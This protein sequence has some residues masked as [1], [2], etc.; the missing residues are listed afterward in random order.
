MLFAKVL[1]K[2]EEG[3]SGIQNDESDMAISGV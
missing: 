2:Y 1:R 3:S